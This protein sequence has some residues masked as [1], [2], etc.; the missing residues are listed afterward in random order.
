[1]L[2]PY[3]GH[4]QNHGYVLDHGYVLRGPAGDYC[5]LVAAAPAS[6][7]TTAASFCTFA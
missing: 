6:S 5:A 7:V 4:I 2:R 1:M 3:S